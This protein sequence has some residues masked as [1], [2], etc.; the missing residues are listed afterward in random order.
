MVRPVA[1]AIE[2]TSLGRIADAIELQYS[3]Q[4]NYIPIGCLRD[5]NRTGDPAWTP[6]SQR[7]ILPVKLKTPYVL[8]TGFEPVFLEG[9]SNVLSHLD[10]RSIKQV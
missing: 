2:L 8:R 5:S 10:E 1:G 7:G 3:I 4:L 6:P 9:K